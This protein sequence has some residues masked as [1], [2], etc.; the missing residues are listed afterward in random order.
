MDPRIS[1]SLFLFQLS[2]SSL[3]LAQRHQFFMGLS[4]PFIFLTASSLCKH[5]R[6]CAKK[7]HRWNFATFMTTG[8]WTP[9]VIRTPI[10]A[11]FLEPYGGWPNER[12]LELPL[13]QCSLTLNMSDSVGLVHVSQWQMI[14]FFWRSFWLIFMLG[15][16]PFKPPNRVCLFS[17]LT[18]DY[19][20]CF[21]RYYNFSL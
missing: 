10:M 17:V 13:L 1:H 8:D 18:T 9:V 2:F 12:S 4:F 19:S 21:D 7:G 3:H 20:S 11:T 6:N 16:I 14:P 5:K 15:D